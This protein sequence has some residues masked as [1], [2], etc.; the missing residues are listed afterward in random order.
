MQKLMDL[1]KNSG[2]QPAEKNLVIFFLFFLIPFYLILI[3]LCYSR[4]VNTGLEDK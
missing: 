1:E 2:N 3:T 4:S